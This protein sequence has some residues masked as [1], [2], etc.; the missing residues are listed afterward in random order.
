MSEKMKIYC[1]HCRKY[2]DVKKIKYKPIGLIKVLCSIIFVCERCQGRRF[3]LHGEDN[4]E[5]SI[6]TE[7]ET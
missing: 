4:D 2:V 6:Q 3:E 5:E 7:K 1:L